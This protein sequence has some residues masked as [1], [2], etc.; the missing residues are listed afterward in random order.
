MIFVEDWRL[1]LYIKRFI[2]DHVRYT[3][4]IQCAAGRVVE[5]ISTVARVNDPARNPHGEFYS[6]HIRRGDFFK[7]CPIAES[8]AQ[9]IYNFMKDQV[10]ENATVYVGY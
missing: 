5:A 9:Q 2:R 6:F 8:S 10:P 3:D 7:Q 1:D 4:W